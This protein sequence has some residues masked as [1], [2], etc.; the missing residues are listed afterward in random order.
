MDKRVAIQ[1]ARSSGKKTGNQPVIFEMYLRSCAN[2]G[3]QYLNQDNLSEYNEQE[4]LVGW[5][6][7][8]VVKGKGN[9]QPDENDIL[10]I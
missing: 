10:I 6:R 8:R 7:F 4:V 2:D 9:F 1:F 3:M 5:K